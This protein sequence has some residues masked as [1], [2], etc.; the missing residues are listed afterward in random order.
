MLKK[1]LPS[2]SETQSK[3]TDLVKKNKDTNDQTESKTELKIN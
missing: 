2:Q 1:D 3:E